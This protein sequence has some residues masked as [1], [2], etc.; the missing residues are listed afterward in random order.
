MKL[1]TA[2]QFTPTKFDTAEDKAKF[3]NHFVRFVESDFKSTLFPKWFYT[4]LSMTFGHIAHY[5]QSGFYSEFFE[6]TMD[7]VRFL[8]QTRLA[9]CYGSPEHTY[10]D[11]E[12]VIVKWVVA[13][14]GT[15]PMGGQ[16]AGTIE[17]AGSPQARRRCSV[18]QS[19]FLYREVDGRFST[20]QRLSRNHSS[21]AVSAGQ[22]T[23]ARADK[24]TVPTL[25]SH[26][27]EQDRSY[28]VSPVIRAGGH[29]GKRARLC[30]E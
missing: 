26:I 19:P 9:G 5:N 15:L 21:H 27:E 12:R 17:Q 7:K 4:R 29:D 10:C 1:F 20:A 11:V 22:M 13:R 3:A 25:N 8:E 23:L 30:T 14:S 16:S 24:P 18:N 28:R 6:S 2:E